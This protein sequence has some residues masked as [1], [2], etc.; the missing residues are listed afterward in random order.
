LIEKIGKGSFGEVWIARH[1]EATSETDA[2]GTKIVAVKIEHRSSPKT[3][4]KKEY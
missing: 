3:S 4:L 1:F 2:T